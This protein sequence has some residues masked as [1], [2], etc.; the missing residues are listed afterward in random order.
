MQVQK[1]TKY[2]WLVVDK[3]DRSRNLLEK[4]K[5]TDLNQGQTQKEDEIS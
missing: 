1:E 2:K 4:F 3:K 5:A